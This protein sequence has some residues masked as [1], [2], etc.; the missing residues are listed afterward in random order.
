[1]L[2]YYCGQ[3]SSFNA[4]RKEEGKKSLEEEKGKREKMGEET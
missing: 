2:S 4:S 1:M 3:P